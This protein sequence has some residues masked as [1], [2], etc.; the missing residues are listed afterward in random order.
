MKNTKYTEIYEKIP[1]DKKKVAEQL[2][3]DLEFMDSTLSDLREIIKSEGTVEDFKQ[4]KQQFTRESPAL[5]SY[6]NL[7]KQRNAT[8][9][10]LIGMLPKVE[11]QSVDDFE[12]FTNEREQM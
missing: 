7:I 11:T 4:G 8:Y 10:Q 12:L 3:I 2:I 1:E 5:K 6:T 9:T